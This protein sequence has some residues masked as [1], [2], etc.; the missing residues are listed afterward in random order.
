M[1]WKN[2]ILTQFIL[3]GIL[4]FQGGINGCYAQDAHF[5]Q[6]YASGLYLNPSLVGVEEQMVFR[7]N[8]R[9]QWR[10]VTLP[11]VTSQVSAI[12]PVKLNAGKSNEIHTGGIGVS[13]FND[14]AGD[15][16]FRTLGIYLSGAYTIHL[17]QIYGHNIIALGVQ[18]GLIQK[19]L[20][21]TNLEWGA[22]YNP[23]LGFDATM[24]PGEPYVLSTTVNP[25]FSVGATWFYNSGR[26]FILK[27][28]SAY[29]GFAI[30]HF[31]PVNESLFSQ[32]GQ[33]QILPVIYKYHGGIE[34]KVLKR[35]HYNQ[36]LLVMKQNRL[37]EVNIGAY[38]NYQMFKRTE[39]GLTDELKLVGGVW[40]R[41]GDSY[42]VMMGL[43]NEFYTI[44]F[45]YDMNTSLLRTQ[46]RGK[47]ANEISLAIRQAKR[48]ASLR[49]G[50]PRI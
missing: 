46:S 3:F 35:L 9:T 19:Q 38:L 7:T 24:D 12:L 44:G 8:Y 39:H 13:F 36:S 40:H 43:E 22:Q 26:N 32:S 1:R 10:S 34:F 47:G 18:G 5:S 28:I 30:S 23:Y 33:Q 37:N 31:V 15:G 11:Y 29:S 45:S 16:N 2:Y 50:T 49:F 21:F 41:L 4:L 20:D 6:F 14:R 25:D 27:N 48:K 17:G 42:I